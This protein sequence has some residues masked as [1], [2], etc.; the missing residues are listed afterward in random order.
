MRD[1]VCNVNMSLVPHGWS[2]SCKVQR[3]KGKEIRL[4]ENSFLRV[5]RGQYICSDRRGEMKTKRIVTHTRI[6]KEMYAICMYM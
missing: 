4:K 5:E 3:R 1:W 6:Y 2:L